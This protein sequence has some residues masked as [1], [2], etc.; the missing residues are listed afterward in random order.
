MAAFLAL[1]QTYLLGSLYFAQAGI[2]LSPFSALLFLFL[3]IASI[4]LA[5]GV[6]LIVIK[7]ILDLVGIDILGLART[8]FKGGK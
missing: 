3:G 5:V 6:S 2:D 7:I 8:V 4:A 1:L